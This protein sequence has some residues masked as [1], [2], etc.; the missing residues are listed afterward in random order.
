MNPLLQTAMDCLSG[1]I[2]RE[3]PESAEQAAQLATAYALIAIAEELA[4]INERADLEAERREL[5]S[6]ED[7][8]YDHAYLDDGEPASPVLVC[9]CGMG[10]ATMPGDA[11]AK[12][13]DMYFPY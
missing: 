3:G 1:A 5:Q 9:S 12:D 13:C 10:D 6:A 11:H 4:K 7:Y 8:D 2:P